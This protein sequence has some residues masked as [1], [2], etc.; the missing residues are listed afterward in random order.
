LVNCIILLLGYLFIL[1][2]C[3]SVNSAIRS[4]IY[5]SIGASLIASGIVLFLDVW[6]VLARESVVSQ[7]L[8]VLVDAGVHDVYPKRDLDRYDLQMA[9]AQH[10]IDVAGYTLNAWY[11]S[12][13][14][15]V[16]QK[17]QENR[18]LR[19]RILLV[20]PDSV[21]SIH[22]AKLEGKSEAS[23]KD[24]FERIRGKF[25][26]CSNVEIRMI[27]S[28]LT[29]MLFRIDEN[30]YVGPHFYGK[31]SKGTVTL[32]LGSSGW[33]FREFDAEFGRMWNGSTA[34]AHAVR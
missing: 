31:P 13:A 32:E 24:S 29:T 18:E 34:V 20:K 3:A 25:A 8:R 5:I 33:L 22:R 9:R 6:R 16:V 15:L 7:V 10:V 17:S 1:W 21:F 14:D 23:V 12:Y 27:D 30:M 19:V 28:C 26:A 2:G 4:S 11:E